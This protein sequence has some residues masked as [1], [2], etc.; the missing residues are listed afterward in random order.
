[1]E[2]DLM[3]L[4][5]IRWGL[6]LIGIAMAF[7]AMDILLRRPMMIELAS[8]KRDLAS[9]ERSLQDLVGV[10]DVAGETNHLLSALQA[11]KRP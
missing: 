8:V 3:N 1:V 10:K 11:Q 2:K 7:L 6:T 9:V 4:P 5:M